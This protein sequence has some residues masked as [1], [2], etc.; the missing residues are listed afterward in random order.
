[1]VRSEGFWDISLS[2]NHATLRGRQLEVEVMGL[3]VGGVRVRLRMILK[4]EGLM[5]EMDRDRADRNGQ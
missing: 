5:I 2:S 3:G 1:M 4:N